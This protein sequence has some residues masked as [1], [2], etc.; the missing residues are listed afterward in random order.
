MALRLN[1]NKYSLLLQLL[2]SHFRDN[3]ALSMLNDSDEDVVYG[4]ASHHYH[5]ACTGNE[6]QS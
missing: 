4:Y 2:E 1:R 3:P 5:S 6:K